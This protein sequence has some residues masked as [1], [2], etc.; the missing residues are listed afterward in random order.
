[1]LIEFVGFLVFTVFC[2]RYFF[3]QRKTSIKGLYV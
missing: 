1:V 3:P 2:L